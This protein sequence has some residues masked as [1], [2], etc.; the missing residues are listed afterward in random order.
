MLWCQDCT[1]LSR[2]SEI[3]AALGIFNCGPQSPWLKIAPRVLVHSL[4]L[5][6]DVS[7][8]CDAYVTN[9]WLS[10]GAVAIPWSFI[11]FFCGVTARLGHCQIQCK[12][13]WVW[14]CC[15]KA[16]IS[17]SCSYFIHTP[18]VSLKDL[19]F[20]PWKNDW[21]QIVKLPWKAGINR[22]ASSITPPNNIRF[23]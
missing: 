12:W 7:G 22:H 23:S 16:Y 9:Y 17:L 18:R 14:V 15:W 21:P 1:W 11:Y 6:S 3:Y 8:S 10:D 4:V 20:H 13:M 19:L 2:T 5:R